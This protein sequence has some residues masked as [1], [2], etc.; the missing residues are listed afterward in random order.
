MALEAAPN[1]SS[2][3]LCEGVMT[4]TTGI[5]NNFIVVT[6]NLQDFSEI[7]ECKVFSP[8]EVDTVCK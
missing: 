7:K 3:S 2:S 8:W 1:S 4:A 6:E 5:V